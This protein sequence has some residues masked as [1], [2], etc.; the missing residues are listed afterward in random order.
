MT[1]RLD[2][3][4]PHGTVHGVIADGVHYHQDGLPFDAH[5]LLVGD[6]LSDAQ[7]VL[8]ERKDKRAKRFAPAARGTAEADPGADDAEDTDAPADE[9]VDASAEEA[10]D[11]NADAPADESADESADGAADV[12][13]E[14]WL[15]G[16]AKYL[17]DAVRGAIR[18]RYTKDVKTI[19]DAVEFLVLDEKLVP[20]RRVAARLLPK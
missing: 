2:R 9:S 20:R 19:G 8:A 12:D 14:A 16:D 13:L 4:K 11:S 1:V 7:K 5:G 17:F 15:T 10:T 6:G 18:A 3:S